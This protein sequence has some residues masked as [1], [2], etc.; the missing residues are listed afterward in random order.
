MFKMFLGLSLIVSSSAVF[1]QTHKDWCLLNIESKNHNVIKEYKCQ[2]SAEEFIAYIVDSGFCIAGDDQQAYHDL[3][4][5]N[6]TETTYVA[7]KITSDN[8]MY[9]CNDNI[10]DSSAN[11][12]L[13]FK[14]V[15]PVEKT[16]SIHNDG[17]G[18]LRIILEKQKKCTSAEKFL[19]YDYKGGG[20]EKSYGYYSY[21]CTNWEETI[22]NITTNVEICGEWKISPSMSNN[23]STPQ[24]LKDDAKKN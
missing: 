21:K 15:I 12:D 17:I 11:F 1:A 23:Q 3:F 6:K 5:A 19:T 14:E 24:W 8:R 9:S 13:K 2:P 10:Y 4:G 22:P 16:Y 20:N 7:N 18:L